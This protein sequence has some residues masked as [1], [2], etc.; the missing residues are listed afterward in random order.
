MCGHDSWRVQ[1]GLSIFLTMSPV[2]LFPALQVTFCPHRNSFSYIKHILQ[3]TVP[4]CSQDFQ[5]TLPLSPHEDIHMAGG[6][7]TYVYF[8]RAQ[9][10]APCYLFNSD[11]LLHICIIVFESY[12]QDAD[13]RNVFSLVSIVEIVDNKKENVYFVYSQLF[14]FAYCRSCSHNSLRLKSQIL[15]SSHLV[16]L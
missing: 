4:F 9:I 12:R 7:R 6:M 5:L 16:F 13:A 15:C 10:S 1:Q 14:L 8:S 3:E 11:R 2:G